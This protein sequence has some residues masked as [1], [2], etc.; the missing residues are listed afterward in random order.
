MIVTYV[1][2]TYRGSVDYVTASID[3]VIVPAIDWKANTP[4]ASAVR[5]WIAEGGIIAPAEQG[6]PEAPSGAPELGQPTLIHHERK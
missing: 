2:Y 5:D 1:G 3:G 4:H 6:A